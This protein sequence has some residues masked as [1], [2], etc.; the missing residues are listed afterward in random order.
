MTLVQQYCC[1]PQSLYSSCLGPSTKPRYYWGHSFF[2]WSS[3]DQRKGF[4]I[5]GLAKEPAQTP[6]LMIGFRVW[7]LG[8]RERMGALFVRMITNNAVIITQAFALHHCMVLRTS[9]H[10]LKEYTE[11]GRRVGGAF[12]LSINC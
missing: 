12:D 9:L 3:Q 7:G 11:T 5:A 1:I 8:F 10:R 2:H 4:V 6:T